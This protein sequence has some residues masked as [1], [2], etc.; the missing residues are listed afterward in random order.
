MSL[1]TRIRNVLRGGALERDIQREMFFHIR[2]HA[3]ELSAQGM[4]EDDALR[5]ARIRFGNQ[6]YHGERARDVDVVPW[7]DSAVG[8]VRHALRAF[9]RSPTF[10]AVAVTTLGLAIGAST[11]IYSLIDAVVLR[12]LPVTHPEELVRLSAGESAAAAWFTNPMWE[13]IEARQTGL[14]AIAAFD[15]RQVNVAPAGEARRV[16]ASWVSGDYFRV[17]G[18]QPALGRLLGPA[19]DQR[20]CPN[21]AVLGYDFWQRELGGADDVLGKTIPVEGSAHRIVGVAGREFRGPKVGAANE[22]YVPLCTVGAER[23]DAR[24]SWWLRIIGRRQVDLSVEQIDA[25]MAALAPAAYA[26]TVPPNWSPTDQVEYAGRTLGAFPASH[27]VS[28]VRTTYLRPLFVMMGAVGLLLLIACANL[29]NLLLARSTARQREV[30]VRIA[31]G[32]ARARVAR[33]LLTESTVLALSGAA[34]GLL[35]SQWITGGLVALISSKSSPVVLD[36]SPHWRLLAFALSL[37]ALTVLLF[38]VLPAWRG[39]G[40]HP[41]QVMSA[42]ARGIVEGQKRPNLGKA[43]VSAQVALSVVLLVGAGLLVGSLRNLTLRDAGFDA[44]GVL[45]VDVDL[46]SARLDAAALGSLRDELI[47]RLTKLPG[48]RRAS[49]TSVTP[50]GTNSWNDVVLVD[51]YTPAPREDAIP[52]FNEVSPGYFATLGTQILAG[53]DFDRTDVPGAPKTVIVNDVMARRYFGS[54]TPLGK[55]FRVRIPTG[56]SQPYTIVGVVETTRYITLRE[57]PAPIAY[58]PVTQSATGPAQL[59]FLLRADGDPMATQPQV[60]GLLAELQPLAVVDFTSLQDQIASSLQRERLLATL[61][62]F[63]GAVALLL[64]M[65]GLYGIMAYTVARRRSEI[66]LRMALGAGRV[67][68]LR[69]VLGDTS[70]VL[71]A[72]VVIGAAAALFSTRAVAS[73]LYGLEPTDPGVLLRAAAALLAVGAL[74]GLVPAWRASRV[75]PLE[76]LRLE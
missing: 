53:R 6:T 39:T 34:T 75:D 32:A 3:D 64:S 14:T 46:R 37:S 59:T 68:V 24:T 27:G 29:A 28:D 72:G 13:Q 44:R 50:L 45:I 22:L 48:V 65:L 31:M 60:K 57:E 33:Q 12:P 4:S 61:S 19:D 15:E 42:R 36:L 2:E 58:L 35:L 66:G 1:I 69:M 16:L 52:W 73:Y 26:A 40:V 23:L 51:G 8:D 43:L 47:D 18:V 21:T 30:A 25:R 67:R 71:L 20:G 70:R 76:S 55:Q 5:E 38:G 56:A 54:E 62:G 49:S 63:F 41:Q 11:A 10:S 9:R 74:S 17:F 7:L